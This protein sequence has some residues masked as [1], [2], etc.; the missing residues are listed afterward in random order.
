MEASPSFGD[1]WASGE[2][3]FSYD[4][5]PVGE[6]ALL[7]LEAEAATGN[8][9]YGF[10]LFRFQTVGYGAQKFEDYRSFSSDARARA[11]RKICERMG[12]YGPYPSAD[13]LHAALQ[14]LVGRVYK[15]RIVQRGEYR[16]LFV[17]GVASPADI[18]RL[19]AAA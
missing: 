18:A 10:V 17:D 14:P 3:D 11:A 5:P 4:P 12:A 16:N 19:S 6:Y 8:D 1:Q 9:G 15:A 13:G 2:V 7:L